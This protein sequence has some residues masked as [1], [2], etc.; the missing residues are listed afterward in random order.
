[1]FLICSLIKPSLLS[2]EGHQKFKEGVHHVANRALQPDEKAIVMVRH[3]ESINNI[4]GHGEVKRYY[5]E[6]EDFYNAGLARSDSGTNKY[7]TGSALDPLVRKHQGVS[8]AV[9]LSIGSE[10]AKDSPLSDKGK[11]DAFAVNALMTEDQ[12]NLFDPVHEGF[13]KIYF[14]PM[15]R[16]TETALRVL[17]NLAFENNIQFQAEPYAHEKF[18]TTSDQVYICI[19]IIYI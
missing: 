10:G 3:G 15:R 12:V 4:I 14:S 1:M 11:R 13:E 8:T 9:G 6:G 2:T 16:T 17:G 18:T 19:Y 7:V 5:R